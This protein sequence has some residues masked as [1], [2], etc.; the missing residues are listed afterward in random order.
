MQSMEPPSPAAP[1]EPSARRPRD[2]VITTFLFSGLFLFLERGFSGVR[3]NDADGVWLDPIR[4]SP[5]IGLLAYLGR[6]LVE[7]LAIGLIA[8]L[9]HWLSLQIV[10]R[11]WMRN[12]LGWVF[13]VV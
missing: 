9:A 12:L 7:A 8:G 13:L 1:P 10:R 11:C 3:I 4:L 2:N 5:E 6:S